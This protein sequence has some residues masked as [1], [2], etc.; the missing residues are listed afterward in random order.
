MEGFVPASKMQ[1][2][3]F[4][5]MACNG[6][7]KKAQEMYDYYAKDITLPDFDPV[8]PSTFTQVK[9]GFK[10]FM[11]FVRENQNE[12]VQGYSFIQQL[13]A[14]KGALPPVAPPSE[15]LPPIN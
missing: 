9:D 7:P 1:L 6:D 3:R 5:L 10:D 11:S 2:K 13:I 14:N 12:L 15:S 4:C 8:T